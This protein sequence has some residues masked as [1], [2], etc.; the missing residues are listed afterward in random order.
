[1]TRHWDPDEE[2]ARRIAAEEL[3]RSR[4][5]E[6][7]KG[8]TAGVVLVAVCCVALGTVLYQFAGPR[9]VVEETVSRR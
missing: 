1:M 4:K 7:P 9:K 5:A 2:L 8:A 3:A 6:W